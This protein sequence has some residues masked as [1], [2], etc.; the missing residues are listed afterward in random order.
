MSCLDACDQFDDDGPFAAASGPV[1]GDVVDEFHTAQVMLDEDTNDNETTI[2]ANSLNEL[3]IATGE[4]DCSPQE[5]RDGSVDVDKNL[6]HPGNACR[7]ESIP[8]GSKRFVQPNDFQLLK[9]IGMGAFG[10]VLQVRNKHNQQVLA[11]KVISKRLLNRKEGYVENVRAER[12]ILTRVKHPFVVQMH[13]SFQTKDK[14]FII[15]DYL[16]GG[17]LFLRLGREGIFLEKTAAF[18]LAEII[19]ALDHLHCRNILHR[20]LKPEN[21]LLGSDGH[22]VLTDFGLAKQFEI[23]GFHQ[24]DERALTVCGTQEYMAPEMVARQGYGRAADYWSLG[25]IAYEMLEGD[26]PFRSKLGAKDLFRKIM[27]EK[28]KM[29]VGSSSAAHKLLKGLLHRN[30]QQRWGVTKSTTFEVGGVSAIQQ[31]AFFQGLDWD[32]LEHK[33]VDPPDTFE[34]AKDDD[35]RHFHD[36]FTGMTLP[37]SVIIMTRDEYKPK[38]VKSDCF[39]GFSFVQDDFHLPERDEEE[40]KQY[41]NSEEGDC[42]SV[43]E[44][45]SSKCDNDQVPLEL[46]SPDKKKRPPRKKKKKMNIA[47]TAEQPLV[48]PISQTVPADSL[49]MPP[50]SVVISTSTLETATSITALDTVFEAGPAAPFTDDASTSIKPHN[51]PQ[52]AAVMP[53]LFKQMAATTIDSVQQHSK[54]QP[55]GQNN[56]TSA[57]TILSASA[58]TWVTRMSQPRQT[59]LVTQHGWRQ[60]AAVPTPPPPPAASPASS[61]WTQHRMSP[62]KSPHLSTTIR[63][64]SSMA[65]APVWPTLAVK[66]PPLPSQTIKPL[67]NPVG[68][69][70]KLQG[71]WAKR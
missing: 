45:A 27:T 31:A 24:D 50:S 12:D 36:E 56:M 25:C 18:Y 35:T 4:N 21:I 51:P 54:P 30:P 17:E 22:L 47:E 67:L 11:M 38:H 20:D 57:K 8:V 71:A 13:C 15:M 70:T 2:N 52:S 29:P 28:V 58:P 65:S 46:V 41:W 3:N 42:E 44:C 63:Q 49:D 1:E 19:L 7:N 64:V 60:T 69:V 66:D 16:A 53:S 61:D 23:T 68:P 33:E 5:A 59:A 43:S 6:L 14:L 55:V 26:P 32:K 62:R 39:R 10:K 34:I 9:V 40:V 48:N 37:R